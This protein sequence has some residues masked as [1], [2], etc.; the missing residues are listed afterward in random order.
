MRRPVRMHMLWPNSSSAP[1]IFGSSAVGEH[2]LQMRTRHGH[3]GRVTRA[4][5]DLRALDQNVLTDVGREGG[6]SGEPGGSAFFS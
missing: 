1:D 3:T 4:I 2:V 5:A 6:A